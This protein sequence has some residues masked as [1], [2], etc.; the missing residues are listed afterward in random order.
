MN[1]DNKNIYLCFVIISGM[2]MIVWFIWHNINFKYKGIKVH[3]IFKTS[4]IE[5]I[6]DDELRPNIWLA[7]KNHDG[8]ININSCG[9]YNC[10]NIEFI[11]YLTERRQQI[12]GY[13][14]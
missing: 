14:A 2:S 6:K 8:K 1:K 11:N 3:K 5:A 9:W 7:N 10:G 4:E 13:K 12:D